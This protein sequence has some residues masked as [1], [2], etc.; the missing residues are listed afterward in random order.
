MIA[1]CLPPS[2]AL[3]LSPTES[4]EFSFWTRLK[5]PLTSAFDDGIA[6]ASDAHDLGSRFG[7]A[8]DGEELLSHDY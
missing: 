6:D 8:K 5:T 7:I 2:G 4:F 1:D 3:S